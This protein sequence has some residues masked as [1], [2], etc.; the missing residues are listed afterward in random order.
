MT[1]DTL[2][3][4]SPVG[5]VAGGG[6]LPF[7]VGEALATRGITPVIFAIKGFCDPV[8]VARFKHHWI[9]LGQLGRLTRLLRTEKC[10]DLAFIGTLIRPALSEIRLDWA[11]MRVLPRVWAAF[12]G[13]D[14]HLLSSIGRLLEK[15]GFRLVGVKDLAPEL[16][17][18]AGCLTRATPDRDAEADIARGREVL[19]ALGPFD[20]GQAAVVID[21]HV[22]GVE[23]IEGTDALLARIAQLRSERRIRSK[24]QRGVLVKMPKRGQDLRLDLP[25][26]GLQTVDGV[27]AAGLAGLATVAGHT[28]VADPQPMID[29]ADRAGVFVIGLPT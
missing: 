26:T 29:A 14:D 19:H 20:I 15:D 12:R 22:V 23:G 8:A 7:A 16:L 11:T 6:V 25:T 9:S 24:L 18:P 28:I 27:I 13:G 4:S 5:L 21:G 2:P 3:I 10:R 17:M 1:N